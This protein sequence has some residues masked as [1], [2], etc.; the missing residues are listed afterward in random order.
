MNE[1]LL[2]E[3]VENTV[4]PLI[5]VTVNHAYVIRTNIFILQLNLISV[6]NLNS[7]QAIKSNELLSFGSHKKVDTMG[8]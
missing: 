5:F 4:Q 1:T 7:L 8:Y 2:K 3:N 6:S